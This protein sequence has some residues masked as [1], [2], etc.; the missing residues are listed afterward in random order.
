MNVMS[1]TKIKS[2]ALVL[3]LILA[4]LISACDGAAQQQPS[5][6]PEPLPTDTQPPPTKTIPPTPVPTDT[7]IPTDTPK[8]TATSTP[9]RAA[10]RA[11]QSTQAAQDALALIKEDLEKSGLTLPAGKLGWMQDEAM[12][13]EMTGYNTYYYLSIDE[14][15]VANDFILK[16]DITWEST[17]GLV[18]CGF[19]FRSEANFE[20]GKQYLF[21]MQRLSG[22]PD[23]RIAYLRFGEYQRNITGWRPASA[24]DQGQ[25]ATN[26]LILQIVDGEYTVYINDQRIGT[27]PDY[28]V[29]NDEGY[30]AYYGY[31]ESGESTCTFENSWVW[32]IEEEE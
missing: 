12:P 24:I 21:S 9:D 6:T 23:W 18:T 5:G 17:G 3:M 10:T 26:K 16:S 14:Q 13:M 1:P 22:L 29:K 15:L 30:I 11:A 28:S 27:Y 7:P 31:Q 25:G 4:L 20:D 8:P 19:F 32:L 2:I